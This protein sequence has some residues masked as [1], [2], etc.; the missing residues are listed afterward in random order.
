MLS[1]LLVEEPNIMYPIFK[2]GIIYIARTVGF[3]TVCTIKCIQ[4]D[5]M[6]SPTAEYPVNQWAI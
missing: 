1:S 3:P 6:S 4:P 2:L 5:K